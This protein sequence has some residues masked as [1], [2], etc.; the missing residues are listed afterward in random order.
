M[1]KQHGLF[2]FTGTKYKLNDGWKMSETIML[3]SDFSIKF[4]W[5]K[6]EPEKK[7]ATKA[8]G[9][10]CGY[11]KLLAASDNTIYG[12]EL[13]QVY[14]KI[15][16]KKQGSKAFKRALQER[17]CSINKAVK[18]FYNDH[19][20]CGLIVCENLKNVKRGSKFSKKFNNKLQRWSYPKVLTKL[21]RL[22]ETEGFR[23]VKIPPAYTSQRC[24][25]CN[26]VVKSNRQGETYHCSICEEVCDADINAAINIL[27]LGVYGLQDK[28]S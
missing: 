5:E 8:V 15:A 9:V 23:L 1:R 25:V 21:E 6:E 2:S 12:R 3:G 10:D 28:V 24:H 11:K 4:Y 16:R 27:R 26:S 14:E 22:S 18:D 20:D 19:K 7:E 17:D 13:E